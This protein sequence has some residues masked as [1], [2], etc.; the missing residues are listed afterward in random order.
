MQ[1]FK[2]LFSLSYQQLN[3]LQLDKYFMQYRLL[4][5]VWHSVWQKDLWLRAENETLY[6][7]GDNKFYCT[8]LSNLSHFNSKLNYSDSNMKQLGELEGY[9][10]NTSPPSL[11]LLNANCA[12][13]TPLKFIQCPKWWRWQNAEL[14]HV[15]KCK[16]DFQFML[17][18]KQ[19][20]Y[21]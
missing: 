1:Y 14:Q 13:S 18:A 15:N 6:T 7:I 9:W 11:S 10:A 2:F 16:D 21:F 19:I 12:P 8:Y 3:A 4:S 20:M 5:Y 17:T